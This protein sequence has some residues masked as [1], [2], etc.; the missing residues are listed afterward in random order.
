MQIRIVALM[1]FKNP[2]QIN[3]Y[4]PFGISFI[5]WLILCQCKLQL[6]QAEQQILSFMNVS[7]NLFGK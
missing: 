5:C 6:L 2:W 4:F 3:S 1:Y 7:L